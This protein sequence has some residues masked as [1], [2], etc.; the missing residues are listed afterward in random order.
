MSNVRRLLQA[1]LAGFPYK[2]GAETLRRTI[3]A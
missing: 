3:R 1:S 2:P